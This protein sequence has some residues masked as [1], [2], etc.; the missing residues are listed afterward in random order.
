MGLA[1]ST[2][3]MR[4]AASSD[5]LSD[6]HPEVINSED[7]DGCSRQVNSSLELSLRDDE[8]D[9]TIKEVSDDGHSYA[10][11]IVRGGLRGDNE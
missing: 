7:A 4:A 1:G 2:A 3:M 11:T 8:D 5:L 10:G 9:A 6:V